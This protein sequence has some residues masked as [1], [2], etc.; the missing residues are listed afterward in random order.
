MIL[1]KHDDYPKNRSVSRWILGV[2]HPQ[3]SLSNNNESKI[4]TAISISVDN[5]ETEKLK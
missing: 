1:E 3:K 5:A 2:E 4:L